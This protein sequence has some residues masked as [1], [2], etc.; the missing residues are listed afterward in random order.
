MD[1]R[2]VDLKRGSFRLLGNSALGLRNGR[3]KGPGADMSLSCSKNSKEVVKL[4]T[5]R[6][7]GLCSE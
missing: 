6:H 4:E 1:Y 2:F 3:H 7:T 5:T